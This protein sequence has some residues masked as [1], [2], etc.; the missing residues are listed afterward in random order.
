MSH[1]GAAGVGA[2]GVGATL[3]V[4]RGKTDSGGAGK[5]RAGTSPAPTG[6]T[7]GAIIGAFKSITTHRYI[8]GVRNLGWLPFEKRLWQR[9]YYE[10]IIRD[11]GEFDRIQRYIES[12]PANWLDDSQDPSREPQGRDTPC[13]PSLDL[14]I[15][16]LR[17][18][19]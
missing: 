14:M 17:I 6:P 8:L 10:H 18:A 5:S 19:S 9:N 16:T 3:V 2:A 12:N 13:L 7:L 4:A 11:P 1:V 15:S